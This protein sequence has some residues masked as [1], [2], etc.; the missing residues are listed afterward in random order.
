MTDLL[1]DMT[2]EPLRRHLDSVPPET[3]IRDIFDRYRV[4]ESYADAGA[5]RIVK[6]GLERTLPVYTMD[7]P[8]CGLDNRIVVA[9]PPVVPDHLETLL[10]PPSVQVY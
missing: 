5:R 1:L 7:E 9:V 10:P 3:P 8:G 2:I 6:P 4:W